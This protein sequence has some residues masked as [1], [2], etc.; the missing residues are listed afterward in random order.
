MKKEFFCFA[1]LLGVVIGIPLPYPIPANAPKVKDPLE[2][3]LLEELSANLLIGNAAVDARLS[4]IFNA[5]IMSQLTYSFVP[6][7]DE[8]QYLFDIDSN[9]AIIK[10]TQQIDRDTLCPGSQACYV[11]LHVQ[12]HPVSLNKVIRILVEILDIN[13]H[14]PEFPESRMDLTILESAPRGSDFILPPAT[15]SDSG[16]NAIQ[17]YELVGT[18]EKF[19]L[20]VTE[21][22]EEPV[23]LTLVLKEELDREATDFY[24]LKLVAHDGG[25]PS[26]SGSIIISITIEDINDNEPKFTNTTYEAF[27]DENIPIGS[28]VYQVS[29]LDRDV[30]ENGRIK[31]D[32]TEETQ[33]T[34]GDKFGI[35]ETTGQIYLKDELDFEYGSTYLLVVTA[36]DQGGPESQ[37]GHATVIVRVKDDNDNPPKITLNTLTNSG[38]AHVSEGSAPGDAVAQI[39]VADQDGGE[40]GKIECT[41]THEKFALEAVHQS[42]YRIV[43]SHILD[44]EIK[45]FYD[46]TVICRDLGSTPNVAMQEVN[47][48]VVDINDE[49]P[50][51]EQRAYNAHIKELNQIND[52]LIQ[53]HARDRD[54]GEN[55]E[56]RYS[57]QSDARNMFQIDADSGL[58]TVNTVFDHD[59]PRQFTFHAVANDLGTPSRSAVATIIVS[60]LDE[61]DEIPLFSQRTYEFGI[62]ENKPAGSEVGLVL[63]SGQQ[64]TS[65]HYQFYFPAD[66]T[67]DAQFFRIDSSS[68]KIYTKIT[69]DRERQ[70]V[71]YMKVLAN[72]RGFPAETGSVSVTVYVADQND[73]PP[74]IS[75]PTA[76]NHTIQVSS[77]LPKGYE[78]ITV[79]ASDSDIGGNGKL[80]YYIVSGNKDETFDIH[81]ATGVIS[82]TKDLSKVTQTN[83][84]LRLLVQDNGYPQLNV[85]A[86]INIFIN[87]TLVHNAVTSREEVISSEHATVVVSVT[88][89]VLVFIFVALF[90]V[91]IYLVY[92]RAKT[93]TTKNKNK[94][95]EGCNY[96]TVTSTRT[97]SSC[98]DENGKEA[99][100]R[101][102]GRGVAEG[103]EEERVNHFATQSNH[104]QPAPLR[105]GDV[106]VR[107]D[108]QVNDLQAAKVH[109]THNPGVH[110]NT[111]KVNTLIPPFI[112]ITNNNLVTSYL[113]L[114]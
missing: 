45:P 16:K 98:F 100:Q 29:A 3:F 36:S 17:G 91:M 109:N 77:S 51:F 14:K 28:S 2:Y 19:E 99:N 55:G 74:I 110:N 75:F 114:T 107:L 101:E 68:G 84:R 79:K 95:T 94:S 87:G 31:Y 62:F 92:R 80:T 20:Q 38:I 108:N 30:G 83:F 25:N 63:L 26:K 13:D 53:I 41:L 73:N 15:D 33:E 52:P 21:R 12:V 86:S 9:N 50:E 54:D 65:D 47:V 113:F 89:S 104:H 111:T 90:L 35:F 6:D 82:T 49:S 64:Q 96:S 76:R 23:E 46:L 10:T 103:Q 27:I 43:T 106:V 102:R 11:L 57:L 8:R 112:I 60:I 22:D 88:A 70:S 37:P 81:P 48:Q 18:T 97:L 69:L 34:Y 24:E 67:E 59:S 72:S 7:V 56:V 4:D 5:S 66:N 44:R 85:E 78:V 40:N 32:F 1:I 105:N 61:N 71:Y 39:T 93:S 58:I 42:Q